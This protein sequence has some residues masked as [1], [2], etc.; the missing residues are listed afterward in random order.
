[1]PCGRERVRGQWNRGF[2]EVVAKNANGSKNDFPDNT[3][4]LITLAEGEPEG[5]ATGGAPS[6]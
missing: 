4:V 5:R 2:G 1:M 6:P 3:K